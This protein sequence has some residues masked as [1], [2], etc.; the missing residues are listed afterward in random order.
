MST[1]TRF[2]HSF[3]FFSCIS[4]MLLIFK[5]KTSSTAIAT[6]LFVLAT[7]FFLVLFSPDHVHYNTIST[8]NCRLLQHFC[9]RDNCFCLVLFITDHA[10]Y[11]SDLS[12]GRQQLGQSFIGLLKLQHFLS[13]VSDLLVSFMT[14]HFVNLTIITTC[15]L[16]PL[17]RDNFCFV[18]FSFL[19]TMVFPFRNYHCPCLVVDCS[20]NILSLW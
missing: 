3:F 19:T 7:Y 16:R 5:R 10:F 18:E 6:F 12:P 15:P 9:A 20:C 1:T 17:S 2:L 8:S 14:D 4:A 13:C 11:I